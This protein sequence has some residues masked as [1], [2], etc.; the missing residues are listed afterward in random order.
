M[1]YMSDGVPG[2]RLLLLLFWVAPIVGGPRCNQSYVSSPLEVRWLAHIPQWQDLHR[3]TKAC[4]PYKAEQQKFNVWVQQVMDDRQ[5]PQAFR[6]DIF[7]HHVVHCE[8]QPPRKQFLE[9][10]AAS[11]R[12]PYYPC[13]SKMTL[14]DTSYL[15]FPNLIDFPHSRAFFFDVGSTFFDSGLAGYSD[16]LR[17]F[18]DVFHERGFSFGEIYAWE[19]TPLNASEYWERVPDDFKHKMHFFNTAASSDPGSALNPL[20]VV[21]AVARP[22]DFVAFKLDI[23]N[24]AVEVQIIQQLI[25]DPSLIALVDELFWENHVKKSPMMWPGVKNLHGPCSTLAGSYHCFHRMRTAGIRA[26]SW[27]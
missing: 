16:S 8:G 10:L 1:P 15:L 17:W 23:D 24:N 18:M 3:G 5:Q 26:H 9:P 19:I 27:V 13:V 6:E 21:A 25:H 2:M 7:S 12:H 4:V 11:L 20:N 14:L 22:E